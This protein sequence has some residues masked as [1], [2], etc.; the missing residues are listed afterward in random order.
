M[1]FVDVAPFVVVF[2]V[3]LA[4]G[5]FLHGRW[6]WAGLVLPL[7]HLVVSIMTGRAGDDL[8]TYVIPINAFLLG[9]AAGGIV[10]GRAWRHSARDV[11]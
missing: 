1:G 11:V 7:L 5:R 10:A 4:S 3:G 2:F 8:L 6:A 9:I